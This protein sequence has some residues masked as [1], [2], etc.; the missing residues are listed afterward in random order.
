MK[1]SSNES[2]LDNNL[3]REKL[4]RLGIGGLSDTDLIAVLL[5][6]GIEGKGIKK[7]S[8]SVSYY[9]HSHLKEMSS[10]NLEGGVTHSMTLIPEWRKLIAIKGVG[11]VKAMQIQCALELGRRFFAKTNTEARII[12]S[13]SDVLSLCSYLKKMR[14]EHVVVIALNARNEVIAKKTVAIGSLNKAVVEPRDILGWALVQ[15]ASGIVLVHNHPSGSTEPSSADLTFTD[16][17]RKAS[18]LLG[19]NFIDHVIV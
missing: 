7:L 15:Y 18:E 16:K 4:K 11:E 6:S 3:P 10:K 9:M 17:I 1:E 12:R 5:G 2:A 8:R 14:Q 13:R 19:V